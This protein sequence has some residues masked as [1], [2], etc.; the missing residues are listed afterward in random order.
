MAILKSRFGKSGIVL[1]DVIFDNST[2]QID[3]DQSIKGRSF[4]DHKE[5]KEQSAQERVNLLM[6]VAASNSRRE[7]LGNE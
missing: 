4:L 2:I 7:V 1:E 6:E 3:M 5:V